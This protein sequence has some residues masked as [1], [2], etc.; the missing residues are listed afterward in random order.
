MLGITSPLEVIGIPEVVRERL[1]MQNRRQF[2]STLIGGV[3][4]GAAVRSFPFRVFSFPTEIQTN[5]EN[6]IKWSDGAWADDAWLNPLTPELVNAS[7]FGFNLPV[8]GTIECIVALYMERAM[9]EVIKYGR[10]TVISSGNLRVP[11]SY[12]P[13]K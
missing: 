8:E 2:L 13:L 6:Y 11:I 12:L 5:N 1:K 9:V 7:G 3:A 4:A 10:G